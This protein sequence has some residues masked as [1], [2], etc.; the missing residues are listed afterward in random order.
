[1]ELRDLN[2][3]M[4]VALH[5]SFTK[6]AE[7]SFITQ[8]SLSK[9]VKKLEE[10]LQVEL[11]DRSTRHLRLTDAGELV[12]QQGQKA[13]GA[14]SELH[15]LLDELRDIQAGEIKIGIPPLI[16]TLFFPQIARNF[17]QHYPNVHLELIELGAKLIEQLVEDGDVDLGI[18]VLPVNE[19]KFTIYPFIQEP[20][21]LYIHED[22]PLAAR[23]SV[24]LTDLQNEP[25]ILF[26]KEFTLHDLVL[27]ACENAGFSPNIAYRSSQWDLII[28]LISLN[29][30]IALLPRMIYH[31]QTN[32]NI[33]IVPLEQ[34]NLLWTLGLIT[35][36]GA[37]HPHALK[38]LLEQLVEDKKN[39]QHNNG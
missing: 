19:Q 33:T 3:F 4:N 2:A 34:P 15:V 8:P 31:K 30:G 38:A 5:K 20:F 29:L 1:M 13:L 32:Q 36:K 6:A 14:L 37:Y 22:H 18:I 11:F 10:E 35:K 26:S 25:F 24:K 16:G 27:Q 7:H 21:V 39:P 28:E 9:A 17:H 12:F 23:A